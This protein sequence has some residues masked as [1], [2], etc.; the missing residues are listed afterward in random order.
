[1]KKSKK[2]TSIIEAMIVMLI[3]VVWITGLYNIFNNSQKLSNSTKNRIEAIEIAREWVEAMKNIRDTNWLI[4]AWDKQ[5]CWN[6]LNYNSDC[7]WWGWTYITNKSYKLYQD[8]SDFKW[9]LEEKNPN[10]GFTDSTYRDNFRIY[11]N[12]WFYTQTWTT[13]PT[14][15]TRE[16]K[17][18]N[19]TSTWMLVNSIV[20]WADSSKNWSH[21]VELSDLITNWK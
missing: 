18:T 1:M 16:I 17:I 2:A 7:V 3:I 20:Q 11:K 19:V 12:N 6:S 13:N 10:L 8:S 4:F 14:I 15:F 5:N 9:K 21:K